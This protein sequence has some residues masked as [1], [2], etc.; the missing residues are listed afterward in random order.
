MC[1]VSNALMRRCALVHLK[2][3][4]PPPNCQL[5]IRDETVE[6]IKTLALHET[7]MKVEHGPWEDSLG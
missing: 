2:T 5:L 1:K 6:T 4:G 7:I 3:A